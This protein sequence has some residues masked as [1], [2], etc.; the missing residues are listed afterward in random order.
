M[1]DLF[2]HHVQVYPR[3]THDALTLARNLFTNYAAWCIYDEII[4][5]TGSDIMS[6]AVTTLN[7]VEGTKNK[8]FVIYLHWCMM[9]SKPEYYKILEYYIN[10]F[11]D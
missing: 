8:V 11:D 5:D 3:K 4:T 1:V 6:D 9:R 2:S 7:G 10:S